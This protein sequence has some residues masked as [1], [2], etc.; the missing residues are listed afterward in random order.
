[1]GLKDL[2]IGEFAVIGEQGIHSIALA[3]VIDSALLDMPLHAPGGAGLA[4][5]TRV[6]SGSTGFCLPEVVRF[7]LEEFHAH[8]ARDLVL[9]GAVTPRASVVWGEGP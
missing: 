4:H 5:I 8:V 6:R 3:G 1:M 2:S 9:T 7:V